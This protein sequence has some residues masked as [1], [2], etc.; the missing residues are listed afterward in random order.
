MNPLVL[1]LQCFAIVLLVAWITICANVWEPR[2]TGKAAVFQKLAAAASP[3]THKHVL[4]CALVVARD[5]TVAAAAALGFPQTIQSIIVKPNSLTSCG[6][7]VRRA[8]TLEELTSTVCDV[9]VY[10]PALLQHYAASSAGIEAR[11][12]GSYS[13][14]DRVWKW[15]DVVYSSAPASALFVPSSPFSLSD[16]KRAPMS[17]ALQRALKR[18]VTTLSGIKATA[19]DVRASS[20][21]TL[22]QGDF[23]ILEINGVGGISHLWQVAP[24]ERPFY[25]LGLIALAFDLVRWMPPRFLL[26]LHNIVTGRVDPL[27]RLDAE[28]EYVNSRLRIQ[29][30]T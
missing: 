29:H 4:P 26:G 30:E 15:D 19:L 9:L 5:Q 22:Q 27:Q 17:D 14:V 24:E 28:W 13:L 10:S 12:Y 23:A 25:P 7:G 21:E 16:Y 11:L 6:H 8:T 18:I 20:L 1:L 2:F 3:A